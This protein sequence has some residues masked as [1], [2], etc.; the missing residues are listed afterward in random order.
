[1][2][3]WM[4]LGYR[5]SY[6]RGCSRSFEAAPCCAHPLFSAL[7]AV[8]G[9]SLHCGVVRVP[10]ELGESESGAAVGLEEFMRARGAE[11][12]LL[13]K[14]EARRQE[15][16]HE[17]Y[18][19]LYK[20]VQDKMDEFEAEARITLGWIGCTRPMM[21]GER[22]IRRKRIREPFEELKENINHAFVDVP[23]SYLSKRRK[24]GALPEEAVKV[25]KKWLFEHFSYPYPSTEEKELLSRQT[26]LSP[27]QVNYWFINARVRIWKPMIA[28]MKGSTI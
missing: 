23:G 8:L 21:D 24:R 26:G 11:E 18:L 13:D 3:V 12:N 2:C 20:A 28:A 5:Q 10:A 17:K 22:N 16:A 25:L 19:G 4:T 6:L 14:E 1:M 9:E 27:S 7:C 15:Q